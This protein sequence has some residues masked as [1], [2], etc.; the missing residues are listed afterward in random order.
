MYP[1][2]SIAEDALIEANIRLQSAN[3]QG[4]IAIYLCDDCGHYH[5]TSQGKMN[6]RLELLIKEGKLQKMKE[7]AQWENKLRRK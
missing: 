4:P 6:T 1:T 3:H 5:L 2:E 7:A